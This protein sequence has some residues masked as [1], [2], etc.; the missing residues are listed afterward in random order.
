MMGFEVLKFFKINS[1]G[2]RMNLIKEELIFMGFVFVFC[3][4]FWV[5]RLVENEQHVPKRR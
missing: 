2:N 1:K 5:S 4:G 3:F